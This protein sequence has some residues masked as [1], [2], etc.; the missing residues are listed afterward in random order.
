MIHRVAWLDIQSQ[1]LS[2]LYKSLILVFLAVVRICFQKGHEH[3]M[4]Y[5]CTALALAESQLTLQ[6]CDAFLNF[7]LLSNV[8]LGSLLLQ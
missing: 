2:S 1:L 6:P 4:H 3:V 5:M 8:L 7:L